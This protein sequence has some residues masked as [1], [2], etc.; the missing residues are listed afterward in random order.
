MPGESGYA[1]GWSVQ[2]RGWASGPTYSHNGSDN[3]WY[4]VVTAAPELDLVLLVA[5]NCGL[6]KAD[7]A[8]QATLLRLLESLGI[9][10]D[11]P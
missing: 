8:S 9:D 7:T 1:C 5:S 4:S 11:R 2:T 10:P 3:T 6:E